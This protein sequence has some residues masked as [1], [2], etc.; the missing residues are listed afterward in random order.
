MVE[1]ALLIAIGQRIGLTATLGLILVTGG[2][3]AYLA[4]RQGLG[5]LR[6]FRYRRAHAIAVGDILD[7]LLILVA[8]ALLITPGVITDLLAFVCLAPA[9]RQR[10]KRWLERRF[11]A[12]VD[13]GDF[14]VSVGGAGTGR[15]TT[16]S[17]SSN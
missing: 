1:L 6:K 8:G 16:S 15:K 4:R 14:V 13:R 11:Q 9:G 10:V 5:V 7:G 2:L 17:K 12:A 3:G